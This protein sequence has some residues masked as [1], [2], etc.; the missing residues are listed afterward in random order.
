MSE[1]LNEIYQTAVVSV[2]FPPKI[3]ELLGGEFPHTVDEVDALYDQLRQLESGEGA[4]RSTIDFIDLATTLAAYRKDV[5]RDGKG[6]PPVHVAALAEARQS[7]ARFAAWE[8]G[9]NGGYPTSSRTVVTEMRAVIDNVMHPRDEEGN[10]VGGEVQLVHGT[11]AEHVTGS[12]EDL[13]KGYWNSL[14]DDIKTADL[15][16]EVRALI[17]L[18]KLG[19]RAY[20]LM[21]D[22]VHFH[23]HENKTRTNAAP[24]AEVKYWTNFLAAFNSQERRTKDSSKPVLE[25]IEFCK[26][27]ANRIYNE[28]EKL[29]V[30]IYGEENARRAGSLWG[31]VLYT[32]ATRKDDKAALKGVRADIFR[33]LG[34]RGIDLEPGIAADQV[35]TDVE[36]EESPVTNA[37]GDALDEAESIMYGLALENPYVFRWESRKMLGID[38]AVVAQHKL[39]I[40]RGA[41][42]LVRERELAIKEL[43]ELKLI[44]EMS[45]E[46]LERVVLENINRTF[47]S[48]SR[49]IIEGNTIYVDDGV[50]RITG[51]SYVYKHDL[52]VTTDGVRDAINNTPGITPVVSEHNDHIKGFYGHKASYLHINLS[53]EGTGNLYSDATAVS[54]APGKILDKIDGLD[55]ETIFIPVEDLS[56]E[57]LAIYE[58]A[59]KRLDRRQDYDKKDYER[60]LMNKYDREL[61]DEALG[62][63]SATAVELSEQFSEAETQ[64]ALEHAGKTFVVLDEDGLATRII[65]ITDK[66]TRKPNPYHNRVRRTGVDSSAW[67]QEVS[68]ESSELQSADS[69]TSKQVAP[70]IRIGGIPGEL[71]RLINNEVDGS[72]VVELDE[73]KATQPQLYAKLAKRISLNRQRAGVEEV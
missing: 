46:S 61:R 28:V 13:Y 45:Q 24:G 71:N 58:D 49:K 51:G 12:A 72:D 21:R 67:Y 3:Q 47:I 70:S 44:Q 50:V 34:L 5:E 19:G 59:I 17:D 40:Q 68:Y 48:R 18:Y 35:D 29:L 36:Q 14:T 42:Q 27:Y 66:T 33:T 15:S 1:Q 52:R 8:A 9:N 32:Y 56:A 57:E 22:R 7:S 16:P 64:M 65:T 62:I 20:S 37:I 69:S 39:D 2:D 6:L 63:D 10:K 30:H 41:Y 43:R 60:T 26:G 38:D 53:P 25:G 55:R 23:F 73:L 31:A 4:F 54:M 11:F